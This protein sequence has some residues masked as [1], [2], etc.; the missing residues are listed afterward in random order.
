MSKKIKEAI[1][2]SRRF[3]F[4]IRF[5]KRYKF[6]GHPILTFYDVF[7]F[8]RHGMRKGSIQTRSSAMAFH[9]FLAIFPSL[10]FLFTLIPYVP[11]SGFQDGLLFVLK[12]IMPRSAYE[13]TESTFAEIIKNQNSGLLS[14]GFL[15]AL[16]FSTNGFN[17]MIVAFNKSAHTMEHRSTL[18]RRLVSILLVILISILLV[19][20]ISLI[21]GSEYVISKS[22]LQDGT[23]ALLIRIGRWILIFFLVLAM[24]STIYYI[25]PSKTRVSDFFNAGSVVATLLSLLTSLGFAFYVNNFGQYNKLYGSIG[26]LIVILLWIYFNSF[27]LLVGFELNASIYMAKKKKAEGVLN[28]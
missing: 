15:A 28:S 6:P 23:A 3:R 26:T 12:D 25:G 16:F 27:L 22:F 8:F 18:M 13:A 9:F 20:G 11:V 19:A 5:L 4:I 10:I 1:K 24:I 14:L 7:F 17:A 21:I 2:D